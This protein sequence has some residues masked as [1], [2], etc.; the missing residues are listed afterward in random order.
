MR[1]SPSPFITEDQLSERWHL[2][3]RTLQ[4]WRQQATGPVW[5]KLGGRIVY[6]LDDDPCDGS[7][8]TRGDA[9]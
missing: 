4:R 8:H 9:A 5:L 6:P 1:K 3:R 7:E 2:S